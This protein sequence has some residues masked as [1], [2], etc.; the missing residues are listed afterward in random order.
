MT[1]EPKVIDWP[2]IDYSNERG[3]TWTY[4][5]SRICTEG[6]VPSSFSNR[7]DHLL[8]AHCECVLAG[9]GVISQSCTCIY[10]SSVARVVNKQIYQARKIN[11]KILLCSN[12]RPPAAMTKYILVSG[13]VISGIGKGVIGTVHLQDVRR[14]VFASTPTMSPPQPPLP[15]CFSR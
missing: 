14:V 3:A 15:A 2:R 10:T 12:P 1:V 11:R 9:E 6:N 13:G 4:V 8:T 7:T 5:S